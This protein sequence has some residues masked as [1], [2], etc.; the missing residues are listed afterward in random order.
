MKYRS[1]ETFSELFG[2]KLT[3]SR[4]EQPFLLEE[5]H[6]LTNKGNAVS[7]V[8]F[9]DSVHQHWRCEVV[10][11]GDVPDNDCVISSGL[12]GR[13]TKQDAIDCVCFELDQLCIH[14]F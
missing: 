1:A 10:L 14:E 3:Y 8:H 9:P 7:L 2:A 5:W 12:F 11:R 6:G 13:G 4:R